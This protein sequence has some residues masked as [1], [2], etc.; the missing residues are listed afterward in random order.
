MCSPARPDRH[1]RQL[2][3]QR[4]RR[5]GGRDLGGRSA[6]A[7]RRAVLRALSACLTCAAMRAAGRGLVINVGR[8]PH[9]RAVSG[10]VQRAKAAL[11]SMTC[12]LGE[13][14]PFGV[15]FC[16]I[17]PATPKQT[18][19]RAACS[20]KVAQ[21]AYGASFCALYEMERRDGGKDPPI[22]PK[23]RESGRMKNRR[24]HLPGFCTGRSE[25]RQHTA[26][27]RARKRSP[28]CI[29][30]RPAKGWDLDIV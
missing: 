20:Q 14:K 4:H 28:P 13:M 16:Q 29:S 27:A 10:H 11:F 8:W 22:M 7:V 24:A 23:R 1:T 17:E 18:S 12:A 2:G 9:F 21:Y 26:V 15:R 6:G 19:P 30:Q 3:G 25:F 5:R